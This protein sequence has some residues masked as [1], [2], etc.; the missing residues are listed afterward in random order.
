MNNDNNHNNDNYDPSYKSNILNHEYGH[1]LQQEEIGTI[2]Y[3]S[4]VALPSIVINVVS[5]KSKVIADNYYNFPWEYDA[6]MRGGVYRP[7]HNSFS[8]F[9]SALYWSIIRMSKKVMGY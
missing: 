7:E 8:A 5:R 9:S 6:D 4:Y 3:L 1:T 2:R